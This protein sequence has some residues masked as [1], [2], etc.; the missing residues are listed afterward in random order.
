LEVIEYI[1]TKDPKD[2]KFQAPPG[3][4]LVI[5]T[6]SAPT[7]GQTIISG[8]WV[9]PKTP[10]NPNEKTKEIKS[11]PGESVKQ[12]LGELYADQVYLEDLVNDKGE[13]SKD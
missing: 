13:F 10:G 4:R 12:L 1:L 2:Y 5:S 9:T 3:A 11:K 7:V 8:N 6:S